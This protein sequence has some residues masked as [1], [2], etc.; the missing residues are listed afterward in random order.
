MAKKIKVRMESFIP[1][2]GDKPARWIHTITEKRTIGEFEEVSKWAE[3]FYPDRIR[4]LV[5]Q[6][7][8]MEQKDEED[9]FNL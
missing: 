7:E 6:K 3:M 8:L 5:D 9:F 1:A 2:W 4:F